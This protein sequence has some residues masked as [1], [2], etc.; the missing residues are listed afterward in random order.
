MKT[1]A[2]CPGTLDAHRFVSFTWSMSKARLGTVSLLAI[3]VGYACS[4]GSGGTASKGTLSGTGSS[5][6]VTGTGSTTSN[7]GGPT[8]IVNATGGSPS[9]TQVDGG[10]P[11]R[12]DANGQNC[13]CMNIAEIGT[14]GQWG[15]KPG[16]DGDVAFQT[17]MND[18]QNSNAHVD[19]FKTKPT[20][21]ADWLAN[22]DVVVLQS[23]SDSANAGNYWTFSQAEVS[24]LTDWV[25]AGGAI[26]SLMGYSANTQETVPTNAL[27]GMSGMSYN[28]DDI[29]GDNDCKLL[30]KDPVTGVAN[31]QQM[32]Y[33][34]GG[35]IGIT[36]WIT[37]DPEV[38]NLSAHSTNVSQ[39]MVG[40][41]H[42][43]SINVPADAHV[44]ATLTAQNG[45]KYNLLAGKVVGKGRVLAYCDEWITY[46]SQWDGSNNTHT[47]EDWC[48]GYL[49]QQIFQTSQFWF[50]M[51][52]WSVP[53]AQCFQI[54]DTQQPVLIW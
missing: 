22:Y 23:L 38:A 12:C 13:V 15:S 39:F 10:R 16:A 25:N 35:A 7:G 49:P 52:K 18:P 20:L 21:T 19:L 14:A 2:K 44:A 8:F 50:N 37:T 48:Q 1:R 24:A 36:D 3:L 30:R 4:A 17:W 26:I 41:F 31:G 5:G 40:A 43:R 53:D 9:T 42:G 45:T 47:T 32:C 33:C 11:L 34:S 54:H 27:I 28:Q 46:T 6:S 51:I 29:V